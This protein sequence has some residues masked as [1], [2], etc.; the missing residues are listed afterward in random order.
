[1]SN[2]MKSNKAQLFTLPQRILLDARI[3][4]TYRKLK[5]YMLVNVLVEIQSP[6]N[7]HVTG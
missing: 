3:V 1:M 4:L 6:L 7:S 2:E 5:P